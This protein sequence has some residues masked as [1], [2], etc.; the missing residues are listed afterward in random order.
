[1]FDKGHDELRFHVVRSNMVV[2]FTLVSQKLLLSLTLSEVNGD[3]TKEGVNTELV[4][5]HCL[6][7][8]PREWY[9]GEW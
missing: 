2:C 1:M 6:G 7:K 4:W 9:C 8:A 3:Y 5:N